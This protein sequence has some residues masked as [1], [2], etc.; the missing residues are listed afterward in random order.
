MTS[1][2]VITFPGSNCDR[3]AVIA[4][5]K[6]GFTVNKIWYKESN[7]ANNYDLIMIPGGFSYGDY[8][9]SGA[10]AAIS[11]AM[12]EV[13]RLSQRGVKI[14]GVCNGF[15]ILQEA[16]LLK[17][18]LIRN[19]KMKFI[20]KT[21][22]LQVINN[23]THFTKKYNLGQLIKI[24]VAHMD[25]NYF[26]SQDGLKELQDKDNIAFKY[27]SDCGKYEE[28]L[29]GSTAG[30]AGIFNDQKNI[31][32]MMPHPERA[33]DADLGLKDGIN[34]FIGLLN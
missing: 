22:H 5:E 6:A 11:P 29:N 33:V 32:G 16:L 25:G 3:D 30:I 12:K 31:L 2:A 15:Q 18:S 1:A 20:C 17:G 21:V 24:P 23:Q 28:D 27:R 4:L 26:I 7:I 10:M 13:R 8:L 9:R 19:K 34:M 14:L